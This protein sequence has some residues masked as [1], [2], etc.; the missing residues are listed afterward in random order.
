VQTDYYFVHMTVVIGNL[1]N[2]VQTTTKDVNT[3][4]ETAQLN[5]ESSYGTN[6]K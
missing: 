4:K 3:T 1:D 6:I 2:S 5:Y